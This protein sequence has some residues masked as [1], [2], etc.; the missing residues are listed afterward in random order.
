M[1]TQLQTLLHSAIADTRF[2]PTDKRIRIFLDDQIIADGPGVL[3]WEPKRVVPDYALRVSD[4]MSANLAPSSAAPPAVPDQ[5]IIFPNV[6]FDVHTAAGQ[7]LDVVTG[8]STRAAAAF[9]FTDPDVANLVSFDFAVF[10][11]L[12]E[13]DTIVGHPR[14]PFHRIDIRS[15]SRSVRIESHGTVLAESTR[16]KALFE[17]SI[18][19]IRYYFPPDDVAAGLTPT[20]TQ[21]YCPYKGQAAYFSTTVSGETL[22]DIAWSYPQPLAD[23]TTIDGFI[24]F[25]QEKLDVFVDGQHI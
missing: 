4:V 12:E 3:V 7:S 9:R 11:W 20:S 6:G 18:P 2:Q 13:N 10:D 21:T 1:A 25:Y 22:T 14:D 16:A 5:P 19:G 15:A 8:T 23:A 24:A 17:T